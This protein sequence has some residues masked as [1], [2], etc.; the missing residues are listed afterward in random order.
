[1]RTKWTL[2]VSLSSPATPRRIEVKMAQ[3]TLKLCPHCRD[4]Q[5]FEWQC[6]SEIQDEPQFWL[7]CCC[8]GYTFDAEDP[9]IS[10][11]DAKELKQEELF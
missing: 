9:R 2:A 11:G 4:W 5:Y 6:D 7:M 3:Q 1:M 8:C 10:C